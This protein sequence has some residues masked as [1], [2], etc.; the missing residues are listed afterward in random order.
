[1]HF[2]TAS[3][4]F[5][6]RLKFWHYGIGKSMLVLG[7][8]ISVLAFPAQALAG[9]WSPLTNL[10]PGVGGHMHLLSNG[11]VMVQNDN[12]GGTYGPTWYLL[13]PD[14]A[15]N[16]INGTWTTLGAA[17]DTRLFFASQL[18]KDGR[19]FMAGG[20]YGTGKTT[21][22]IYDPVANI[23]TKL[24][25]SGH[26]F[27]DANSEL[28]PDGR[29]LVALVEGSLKSTLIYDPVANTW[30]NGPT[31]NGI[32]NE[33]AWVKLPD[34][35]ILMVDRLTT[36]AERYI[37]ATN[38]WNNDSTVPV[39]LYDPYGDETGP[40][41]LL[42]NGK[43]IFFGA[44]GHTAIY[45]PSGSTASGTW[46]TGPDFP[47]GQG[48]PDAAGAM[49]PNGKILLATAPAPISGNVFQ[50]PT[51]FYEYDY[52]TNTF[53]QI[54]APTGGTTENGSSFQRTMLVLPDGTVLSSRFNTQLYVY[55]PGGTPITAAKPAVTSVI[56]N[57]D[58]TFHLTGTQLNGI[59]EGACYG[60]DDQNFTNYPI[61][62]LTAG[63]KVYYARTYNWSKTS[64]ATGAT[65]VTT[66]FSLPAGL[67]QI[68][69]TLAVIANGVASD[70]VDF[71]PFTNLTLAMPARATEGDAPVTVTV[72]ASPAPVANLVVTLLSNDT[73]EATV[74]A[75]VT[76]LAG[77]SSATFLLTVV[78]DALLDGTQN[79]TISAT[80]T[81][82]YV[83][84]GVI[85]ID[86]NETAVLTLVVP[87]STIEGAG[88]VQGT[89]TMSAPAAGPVAVTM[90][91]SDLTAVTVPATV[92][93]LNGQTSAA[94]TIT[95]I[96]DNK[97]DGTQNAIITAH[98]ANW[99][100]GTAAIAVLDNETTNLSMTL[101]TSITEGS[102]GTGTVSIS[103]TLTTPLTVS[104]SSDTT[105][106]LTVPA[107]VS[108]PAGST[109]GT[110]T[111]TAPNNALTDG[112]AL[113]TVTA[114]ATGFSGTSKTTTVVDDDPHHFVFATV[115]S[116]QTRGA[117][118]STTIT[119][120]N[121]GNQTATSFAGTATLTAAGSGGADSITPTVTTAF[122]AGVW[123]GTV[124][125]GSFDSNV[126]ITANDGAGHTG[127]S[128]AFNVVA[129]S[130][131]HFAWATQPA[132]RAVNA[133]VTTTIT[134]QDA[135]NNTTTGFSGMVALSGV[136]LSRT[137]GTGTNS[138]TTLPL[139]TYYHDQRSQVIYLQSEI[140]VA[141]TIRGL[142]LNV[143]TLPGQTMNNWTI[144]MKHTA[145]SSYATPSWDSTGWTTVHQS[146]PTISATGLTTFTFTT[147]FAYDGVSNLM[148]DLS[149]NN[150]SY[151]S[152][153]GVTYTSAATNRTIYYYTDSLYGDPLTW[154]GTTNPAPL[155]STILP[156]LQLLVGGNVLLSPTT[157]TAFTNGAWTGAVT[158]QQTAVGLSLRADDGAGHIGDSN[159]FDVVGTLSISV[160]GSATEGSPP[161]TGTVSVSSAPAASLT[162]ALTSSDPA[163]ATVP[164]TVM[165]LAGQTSATFPITI[166]DDALIN[167]TR[168]VAVTAHLANWIDASA[169]IS[170]LDNEALT[171]AL[172]LPGSVTEGTVAT[173]TVSTTGAVANALTVNLSSNNATR[174][175]V[176]AT[177]T[178]AAGSASVTF[179]ATGVDNA[180]TDGSANV[181]V[182]ATAAGFTG[183][184]SATTVLD[185][186]V[187]H[188]TMAGIASPQTKGGA[189]AVSITAQD[190]NGVTLTGYAGT[191]SLSASGTGGTNV[192]SPLT[193]SGFGSGVWNGQITSFV[194]DTNVILT[195]SDGAGHTGTS[196]AFNVNNPANV[197]TV[198]ES[199]SPLNL[200]VGQ[201]PHAQLVVG[202]D[203]SFYG[204]TL[205]G[206]SSNQ[207]SV[208]KITAGG[209][210]TTLA[211]FYGANGLAPYAGLILA[212][213]GN[214][215]GTTSAGGI[216]NLGT[217]F[218]MTPAGVLTTLVHLT[219]ATGG[220]PKAPL[221]QHTD[222]NFYGTTS[223][224]GSFGSGTV[225]KVTNA[226]VLTVLVNFTGTTSTAYGSSCQAGL[227][228]GS[229][230]NLYGVTSAGGSGGGFGTVFKVT[231][232][233]AFTS[234]ASFTGATG[235]APLAA[236][237]QA[238]DGNLYGTTSMGGTGGYGTVFKITTGGIFT[239]L[240]SFTNTSGSFLGN[241]PQ[242]ALVPWTDGNLYGMTS[243]GGTGNSGTIFRVTTAGALTTLR[244]FSFSTDGVTPYGALVLGSDNNFYGTASS[245]STQARGSVFNISPATSTFTR[246]Y[247]FI[248]SPQNYKNMIQAGDGNFYGGAAYGNAG[249][250][251]VFKQVPG[252]VFSTLA[253]FTSNYFTAP[254]LLQA[255][256][257][258]LYGSEPTESAYGQIF[259]LTTGGSMTPLATFTGTSGATLGNNVVTGM[260]QARDGNLYGVTSGG[261]S[262]GGFGTV[263]KLTT[264]GS[265]TSLASFTNT[266]GATLG[267]SPQTKLVQ[268]AN[269]DFWSTTQNGGAGGFGTVFK[270][271]STGVLTTL[272]QFTGTTGAFPGTNPNTNLLLA[273]D[274]NFYG[275]TTSGGT[276]GYGS[277]YRVAP[278]G[279]FTSLVSFTNISGAFL[280]NNPSSNLVQ[281]SDGNL[282][283]TTVNGGT[284]GGNGTVYKLTLA[285]SF[286]SMVSFTGSSGAT[287]GAIPQATLR[288]AGDGALYGTTTFGGLYNIG[289]V[290]RV[291]TSGFFQSLYTFGTNNDGGT[292]NLSGNS[293]YSDA[294]RLI[295]GSDGYV[296]GS[297]ASTI[298][299]VHQQPAVQ[300]V[301]VGSI[302]TSGATLSGSVVPNQDGASAYYQY[303]YG[304][305]YGSQT[306]T[307]TLTPG[308]TPVAVNATLSNLLPGVVYHYRLVTVTPQSTYTT[309][310]Q[311][312]A[313]VSAPL[314]ITGSFTGA[315]QTGFS[316]DGVVNP[317]GTSTRCHFEY[318]TDTTYGTATAAQDVGSGVAN[319]PVNITVNGLLPSS[320]YHVRLVATN[321]Y[322]TTYGDDQTI[323]TFAV[324]PLML[325][326]MY[327]S[328]STGTNPLA[329]LSLGSDGMF[330][331][332]TASGGTYGSGTVF[333]MSP[334][335]TLS[336]LTNF[337]NNTNGSLSGNSP[338][339]SLVQGTDGNFYGTTYN[340]GTI[341]GYGTIFKMTPAGQVTIL[342]SLN[343]NSAPLGANPSCGLTLG[344]DSNFYGVTQSG[345]VS[346]LGSIFKVTPTGVFTTLVSFTGTTGSN[347]GSSP[348]ASLT[349]A[350]DGNFYGAT[351]TGGA[352]GFGTLFKVT[353]AGVLTTLVQFTGTTGA[354]PG[355]TPIAALVQG[356]DGS[357]YG[358]TTLGGVNNLGTVFHVT[359]TAS[360]T[361]LT[362]FSGAS[363]GVMGATPKGALTQLADGNFYGTTTLGGVNNLGSVF[364]ITPAGVLSTLVNFTG[365]TGTALGA[366]PQGALIT[367]PDGALYG[368]TNAG[369]LNNVGS[370]FKVTSGGL[371]TTLVNF[372]AAPS[373]GRLIQ[374]ADGALFGATLG[375]GGA[376]GYG[377][378]FEAPLGGA[379]RLLN[380]LVPVSG[381]TALNAR[382]GL[383]LGADGNYYGTTNSGGTTN[384]GSI[385][386]LTP[387]GVYNTLV[388]FTGTT[389][390]NPG[391]SPQ[392][393]L[394]LGGDGNYYGTTNGGGSSGVG[395]VFK[396]TPAGAQS[397]LINFTGSS[398]AN[399][400]SNPQGPPTLGTDGN[401]YGTTA[402]GGTGGNF[403]T[404]YKLTPAGVLTTL[405]NF[406]GTTGAVLG[407]APSGV[408]AQG[409]DGNY[410][411]TTSSGGLNG[412]GSLFKVTPDGVFTSLASFSGTTGALLGSAPT[413]GLFAGVDGCFY[414]V[415][416]T[417]GN[418]GFGVLF[419]LAPDSS[420]TALYSF[421]GRGE[422]LSPYNGLFL[423]SDGS[424]Y[425]GD[426]TA[427]YRLTPP[428]VVLTAPATNVLVSSA[429]LNGAITGNG[430]SG[431]LYF[432]YGPTTTYG[433]RTAEQVFESVQIGNGVTA[434]INGLQ[435][436]LTYHF[437]L[438][439]V[440]DLGAS[441]GLDQT[442]TTST[443]ITFNASTDVPLVTDGFNANGETLGI[444]LGFNPNPDLILT[445][446]NNTGFTPIFGSFNGLPEGASITATFGRQPRLFVI[447]YHGGD[448]NDI[449]LTAVTQAITFPAIPMKLTS[450]AP[451]ALSATATSGL[452]VSYAITTGGASA[453]LA[454]ST[455]TLTG[456]PGTVTITA[457]QAGNGGS[458][459]AALPVTQ[460]FAV[461]S[462]SPFVQLSSSKANNA[463]VGIRADGTLWAWGYNVSGQLGNG[464]TSNVWTPVQ[465]GTATNWK[466]VST[467]SSHT[468][469][470]KTDGTLWSWGYNNYGQLGDG[471]TTT[472]STPA[473]VGSAT[474]WSGVAGGYYHS[475]ALKS[476]GTLWAW[477]YNNDGENGQGTSD[478]LTTHTAPVQVGSVTTWTSI[479]AGNFHT[480]AQRSDGTLWGWGQNIFGQIGNATATTATAPVQIGIAT[481][482]NS[483]S[484]GYNSSVGTR[485]DG[486][487]WTWG[488]NNDGQLGD[489][490]VVTRLS[491]TQVGTETHWQQAQSGG[492]HVL[493][494]K[495]DGSL[496]AWG[497]N[498]YGQLGQGFNDLTLH[499]S[500]PAQVGT[501]TNWSLLAPGY[502]F[503]QATRSDGT[504]WSWGDNSSGGLG[505]ATR[506]LQPVGAQFGAVASASAGDGHTAL[507]RSDGTLW[508]F[509]NNGNGQ[510]GIGTSDNG[511]HPVPVQMQP[512]TQWLSVTTGG[513][514]T[515]AVR[516][517]GT[518]W[519]WGYNYYG[520]LGDGTT[521]QRASPVQVG[522]DANWLRV[523]AGYYF[524]VGLR[525]DGTLWAWG[526]NTDGQMG[527]GSTSSTGQWSP[528]Q[529]GVATDW[530]SLSSGGYHVLALK[531]N[532]TLWSWGN[533]IFGEVGDGTT[534]SPRS[535]PQ[536]VGTA[537]NW[538]SISAGS[539][540]SVATQQDGTLWSW[541]YNS[542]GGLGDGTYANH[543]IPAKV[544]TDNTWAS[545]S[546]GYYHTL[547]TKLDGTLWSW[548]YNNYGQLGDG[549]TSP[550][551]SPVQVGTAAGWGKTYP[552]SYLTLVTTI[553][554]S[555]WACGYTNRGAAGY[556]WRNE[557][558]PDVVLPGLS[559]VQTMVFPA[560]GNTAIGS[561][562]TLA[563]TA[564]SGLPVSYIVSGPG[565][566]NGSRLTVNG[567][568][569]ITIFAWQPGDNFYQSSD[570]AVQYL[571]PLAPTVTSLAATMVSTTSAT[572]NGIVNPNG[573]LVIASF[574]RGTT[575]AYGTNTTV[576]LSPNNGTLPQ[577][578]SATLGGLTPATTYHFRVAATGV[579]GAANGDD[580]TFTT[581]NASL[582][583]LALSAGT[584]APA[585]SPTVYSYQAAVGSAVSTIAVTPTTSDGNVTVAVNG[586]AV[587]SGSASS[588]IP[589]VYGDN[590]LNIVVTAADAISTQPYSLIVTRAAPSQLT[591]AYASATDVPL[592]INRFTASGHTVNFALNYAPVPGTVLTVVNNTGLGFISGS[593]TNLAH[594]Q[595]VNLSYNG[596][597]YAFVASYYGGTGNDLVLVWA[598]TRPV[599]WGYN[600]YGELGN[601]TT[602]DRSIPVAVMTAGTPLANSTVLALAS[603]HYHSL[604]LGADG[605]LASWG[606]ND[607]GQLGNNTT[608]N[609]SVPVA[610]TT[611]GTPLA[612]KVVIAI[613]GGYDHSFVL[614][615]DGTLAGWGYNTYGQLGNN[616][617]SNSSIPVAVMTAGTP[618]AG[619]SVVALGAGTYHN[620]VLCSDGTLAA[621]GYNTYGNLG[622]NTTINSS[623]PVAV[624]TAGTPLAG[625]SVVA[626]AAGGY[627]NIALCSDGTLATWGENN[628]GQ[629]GNNTTTNSSV[630]ISVITAGTPLAGKTVVAVAA[631]H[632]HSMALCSDGTLVAWGYNVYGQLGNNSTTQSNVPV[633]V[634]TSGVLAGKTVV[635]L[636]AGYYYSMAMCSDGTVATW[637]YNSNGQLGNSSTTQSSIP[638][639]VSTSTL[640]AGERFMQVASGQSAYHS[641]GLVASPVPDVT[642]LAATSVTGTT[643]VL[644]GSV[645]ANGGTTS[646][647][648]DYG[649]DSSYGTNVVGTPATVTG[650]SATTVSTTLT[651]LTPNTSYHFRVNASAITSGT[652]LSFTT[653]NNNANLAGLALSAGTL[654]PAFSS[655]TTSYTASVADVNSSIILTP[656]LVDTN[657]T[658]TVNG[659][660]VTS[661]SA[662]NPVILSYGDN[663]VNVLVTAQDG[664]TTKLFSI[665]VTRSTPAVVTGAYNSATDIPLTSNGVITTGSAVN[666]TLNYAPVPGT[667]LTVVN[668]PGLG[669]FSGTFNN[670]AHGQA[671]SLSY[672]GVAY[673]FVASYYGG[674]GNDLV[675]VWAGTR[676]V[677]WGRNTYGELGNNATTDSTIPIA[678][679]TA[680]TPL[681]GRT[682]LALSSGQ[683]HSLAL[684][685]DGTLASWGYNNYGQLG[686]NTT[687]NSSLPLAVTTAGTP[688]AGKVVAAIAA[689]FGSNLVLCTDGTL[690][691]WGFNGFGQLGNNTINNSSLPIAVTTAGTPLAGKSVVAISAGTQHS[692]VLCADGTLAA[693]GY[694]SYGQ[695]GNNTFTNNYNAPVAVTTA[696]TPLAGKTVVSVVA[697]GFHNL[698]LCSDGTLVTWGDNMYGQLGNSTTTNSSVPVAVTTAGTALAGKTVIAMAAGYF[699]SV[700]LCSDGTLAAWGW[701]IYGQL[702]NG[703]TSQSTVPVAVSTS[704]VLAGKTV[705][706][707]AAGYFHS[708]ARCSDGTV[709]TWGNNTNG[710]LGNNSV[711]SSS[712]PVAVST[713]TL[714]AG[715]HFMLVAGGQSTYHTVALVASPA[716][717]SATTLAAS[718]VTATTVV[719]NGTVN[720]N[721][722]TATVSFDY[723]LTTSYG[724]NV[725]GS[726][727]TVSGGSDTAV[728]TTLSGLLPSTTYHFRVNG[729]GTSSGTDLSF[730]TPNNNANL[731]GLALSVGAL[732]P[733]FSSG[734]TS[735][736]IGVSDVTSSTTLTPTL[737]DT[738][739]TVTVNG[740][741]VS[742]GSA[743]SPIA[744]GYGDNTVNIQVTAQDTTVTRLYS[745]KVTRS[746][747]AQ[748][749]AAYSSA[750]DIPLTTNG[751]I[752]AGSAVNFAL[753]Y[754]P[755]PGTLLT[756]V[757]NTGRGFI[758]GTFTNLTHGQAVGLSYNGV[759][760]SF[761]VNYYG[762][763]GNDLVLVWAG[764]RPV[765]WGY[766][767]FGELGNNTMSNSRS[768]IAV[769]TAD[770]PL[771]GRTLLALSAGQIHTLALC[772][773]GTLASWGNNGGSQ[774]GNNTTIR[775][776]VAV[777]VTTAGT[778][779]AGKV[780]MAVSAGFE[781]NLVL[782]TDGTL[783]SWGYN[784]NGQLGNNTTTDS[785]VPVAVTTAGTPLAGRSVVA[786]SAGTN[787]SLVLCADGTLATWGYNDYGE[788]GN[789][790]ITGSSIPVAV[791]TAGTPLAGKSVVSVAAGSNHNIALCSD[792]TLVTWGN[793]ANGQL[794]NN[795]TT[796]NDVPVA[797]ITT[798][799]V[800]AGKTVIAVAAGYSH[801]LAL[802]SDGT[803]AA[804]G[805]N[806]YGQLGNNSTTQSNVPVAV[807]NSGVLAG[808]TVVGLI[809]GYD[810]SMVTCADGSVAAWG[811]NIN[812]QLGNNTTTQSSIPVLVNTSSFATGESFMVVASGQSSYHTLALVAAPAPAA[813]T[814]AATSVTATTATLTGTI[815]ASGGT[816]S[817]FFDYGLDSSYGTNVAGSPATVSGGSDTAVSTTLT[818]L[819]PNTTYHF[820]VNGVNGSG[821]ANG[822]DLSFTTLDNNAR[823]SSLTLSAGAFTPAFSSAVFTYAVAMPNAT[824]SFTLTP[825][826]ASG[827]A[828]LTVNGS[829]ATS[830]VATSP[831]SFSG[832]SAT[833]NVVVTAQDGTTV[834][835][836]A[837]NLSRNTPYLDW[838]AANNLASGS[839]GFAADSDGDGISNLLEYAFNSNPAASDNKNIL[840][841]GA[842]SLNPGDGKHYFTYTYRRLIVPGTL[843][844]T[845][846]GA[847]NLGTWSA[848]QAQNLIQ[849]G[850]TTPTGDGISEVILFRILPALEDAP[851]VKFFRLKVSP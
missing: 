362:S 786:I 585:F 415:T 679:T 655:A 828:T 168:V 15:G 4:R 519:T 551:N 131:H 538:R 431:T 181:T 103:G 394:I 278:D 213:D 194:S 34:D 411:G 262:G 620:L 86:D 749:A 372:T 187:H 121:V 288:Q 365:S 748:L 644:N 745:I 686:N 719:L 97:I 156:N 367:G 325:Q 386:Q 568:G 711:S 151:T 219:N 260:M 401:Y 642:T 798:G 495:I 144:R 261:G 80:A 783:A 209:A 109:S 382:A 825:V 447:S 498:A 373:L 773:D 788:L 834:K 49:L 752:T 451:F 518:L 21:A 848:V 359:T 614:C 755:I 520:Q 61:V 420:V 618:L 71:N 207:G 119:A 514:H 229:D 283:G 251:N 547:G 56:P 18:L 553:D 309:A 816:A 315:G 760:Y 357:L 829:A 468:L 178:I 348:R 540:H 457:T 733:A 473:Q 26:T 90:S 186:D 784:V 22:E 747:P 183:A 789:K 766:N 781:H 728:S 214:F 506:V 93:I 141:A 718:S 449:T 660:A 759:T 545:V 433:T 683:Y 465:I 663:T 487:L 619:K 142:A 133:P 322:G 192:I 756:V 763:T 60:D 147:P 667:T 503:N 289:T 776:N 608:T 328:L 152:S 799:T 524:T 434:G 744:L 5:M 497:W 313:T 68:P 448:G 491:P 595:A 136:P 380:T 274:G 217:L 167:G 266:T 414:G 212:S 381:T 772:S 427:I 158:V 710:Q 611:A 268:D 461:T 138:T 845:I 85:A 668:N 704:G 64:V 561:T 345:G 123:T 1:M 258:N 757:N 314:V 42:P 559:P 228:Q 77:Q 137:V 482:W 423:A 134:A 586:T 708:E 146:N 665:K 550:R 101:T 774:L 651:G 389:G 824:A 311:T 182:T 253:P 474:N 7:L 441:Y 246:I 767:G 484:C 425:G 19:L 400:G 204:T 76:I 544:G 120:Q 770:T 638:V 529:I 588:P 838:A 40:G 765:A 174:L 726:P 418:Y 265:F 807:S 303:G 830:G 707:L 140:G 793:N 216:S 556:G 57:G 570:M 735:Y 125:V 227:I 264:G 116:P 273:S 319:V 818:G 675:L 172:F 330:Y 819:L 351:A 407:A 195:V 25:N 62:R 715:E 284:G 293:L 782:C 578:V 74:P 329:G 114:S 89:V 50:S 674:T 395:T 804:W 475:V 145:L 650:S 643:A 323:T 429:T 835:T 489:G 502:S 630:P 549:G 52:T 530:T 493:A 691:S 839:N 32:H 670:L 636:T 310:D 509:G 110:F 87:G 552:S 806:S 672:H 241:N 589:L 39:S 211:N 593:F 275:T 566:L 454:G 584:L 210:I 343:S 344:N 569:A 292:P 349:L 390:V 392:A 700:V 661:G 750:A 299:R 467:G 725:A 104:L 602:T 408:L 688:L 808:K 377:T 622:N 30:T 428:P 464:N 165:I 281:A 307:Q 439:A 761:V 190:V 347:L 248:N 364:Q 361:S 662:S 490:T 78:D 673:Q 340:G 609:S 790:S 38:T 722:G 810:H 98:V 656:T 802:C 832:D 697:G 730:T 75:T 676:P 526:Y 188:F 723:G 444:S 342:V 607:Y 596:V 833:V 539:Y 567:P 201:N 73:T 815:N 647:S 218:K 405:V 43:V 107:T 623:L 470:V 685:A 118:V 702:G 669:F 300:S 472:R 422:G 440:T 185:N 139:Y 582:S 699:H 82:Y 196:N 81:G 511:Q 621:W 478:S 508:L 279:T 805:D 476:D 290:F 787:H 515:A 33:S 67:P 577:T 402:T 847:M 641:L 239:N 615:A 768:P 327:Q 842:T 727:A 435:P 801:S 417:G 657:A 720:A 459:D 659:V 374:G 823:L 713:S 287:L 634:S 171:L 388:S 681:T 96:D 332:T 758:N 254:Y 814:L 9:T 637:G 809:S 308:S 499:G 671:V 753:N 413:G 732:T 581:L 624:T 436:F 560:P 305:S 840:P 460:T 91:S 161:V 128:N 771:D 554:S 232:G 11:T 844:Y 379:P 276:G 546:A 458:Y 202:A 126:V 358:T 13:T 12:D 426:G 169:N 321:S 813:T 3:R 127:S 391:S 337:Y 94:F 480:L 160:P 333:R 306:A 199:L 558:V 820:R 132:T 831:I 680:G 233:G 341:S 536:Q 777:A 301:A 298:F 335:G 471:T 220:L 445:L 27:S 791:T 302:T 717:P 231:T 483:I 492:N 652:D 51:S 701:N 24:P 398:G 320:T 148:V 477:G 28:L 736:T 527:N 122:T 58:G 504:L 153:G 628:D 696:G 488:F 111:L 604:A 404:V 59:G 180:L 479:V 762:G 203:G 226:G 243:T 100:D 446:V 245:G 678:V 215:Y 625:K 336:T 729:S 481:N 575:L 257:G 724:T 817:V 684:C 846:E 409:L 53:T 385:Y 587:I 462:G 598:G 442:F 512:G 851:T 573:S 282:Y 629:L 689:N 731:S 95:V 775:S 221:V 70:P 112:N 421:S 803:V 383:L 259:K 734:T 331:G 316:L 769:T 45:T 200:Q 541:G 375:G 737:A 822:T 166:I 438:V 177:V 41:F 106:R 613:S 542:Y 326:P 746:T 606:Y 592:T 143:T 500:T 338:Q 46:V 714:T 645:N 605:T 654:T 176:P 270:I 296:Y 317:L 416:V 79:V 521:T 740:A 249:F 170:V 583:G 223:V 324:S 571:N 370:V 242:S 198:V 267:N 712:L 850:S 664:A 269:G 523:S 648:F 410:Y 794:G 466:Y 150:S 692:L 687:V 236:L 836:Y 175:S 564:S 721:G 510:I 247:S 579:G 312:F 562:V 627:H 501:A 155:T 17:T 716:P 113:V 516:S 129:G 849:I 224:G 318:G 105:S 453:T 205:L 346:G 191:P 419:R 591:A 368:T 496:W 682:L 92:T 432:E 334:G 616:T 399:L 397:V 557:W 507:I 580:V 841:N 800:L 534:T 369:G 206:G 706:G 184:S 352:G 517:D 574:Q 635:G 601:N 54:N 164:A 108:I 157:T 594:G 703:S 376:N 10:A 363:G 154:S 764:T 36:N 225:I 494:Q 163:S 633:A 252:G 555:L 826:T 738:H 263:F 754:A 189:F 31:C 597:T 179:S 280:G 354:Y 452:A 522:T 135:G 350:L 693:W 599:A 2:L 698:A 572:L 603:G 295:A 796:N 437:R 537:T 339:S 450:A 37:P 173:G 378:L 193:A 837:L 653:P 255:S 741:V 576:I 666:F 631:G 513:S 424:F 356:A 779:L 486:T 795:T 297:N 455:V 238:S 117:P 69:Y 14:S 291:S 646:V 99:T 29:V 563:A 115:S 353:P 393:A 485:S 130:L 55:S 16:Y 285:G 102:T 785:S 159:A 8:L 63:A 812:G 531:Q 197:L 250:G 412:F 626:I 690:A 230:G 403:G 535:S 617:T 827:S 23:W 649:L 208:F 612:G 360:F 565:T 272:V 694:N 778:P 751:I 632:Y 709:A 610:V 234:L 162:V 387:T 590:T 72:T 286:T 84:S 780:V 695:V 396:M 83:G 533:N 463:T 811:Y 430:F 600:L 743:G 406:T 6:S 543:S 124:A 44:T 639:A 256:D 222:G 658:V 640:A 66:E 792:G 443:N 294:F 525:T 677:A 797:V 271:T 366:T 742:S 244:S 843:T 532:G 739:A 88:S 47:N 355:S 548:G 304:L 65:P 371:F 20:E 235:S 528:V 240:L 705:V 821:T 237:V 35:S 456:A 384:N 48:C 469:A 505:Y 149:F 277:I